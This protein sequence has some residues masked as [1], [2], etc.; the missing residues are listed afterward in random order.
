[1]LETD[2]TSGLRCGC[3]LFLYKWS[4]GGT[5]KRISF[6]AF[7]PIAATRVI[8]PNLF[9]LMRCVETTCSE[10]RVMADE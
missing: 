5:S 9:V 2:D 10:G 8:G 7:R 6:V 4:G 3:M 1:M